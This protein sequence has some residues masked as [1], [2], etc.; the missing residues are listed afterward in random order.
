MTLFKVI[1]TFS[2]IHFICS[3]IHLLIRSFHL[4]I[5]YLF[6]ISFDFSQLLKIFLYFT[7]TLFKVIHTFI[8]FCSFICSF[9]LFIHLFI[10]LKFCL[11]TTSKNFPISMLYIETS[12]LFIYSFIFAHL[13]IYSFHL[14]IYS[15]ISS[16]S[17]LNALH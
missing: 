6:M 13:S 2:F 5:Y 10:N 11:F 16:F 14:S 15:L 1:H 17:N 12:K 9:H 4:S 8:Y 3:S 7:L